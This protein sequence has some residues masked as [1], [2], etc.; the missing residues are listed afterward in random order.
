MR[1]IYKIYEEDHGC[2][3]YHCKKIN[4][5]LNWDNLNLPS[6]NIYIDTFEENNKGLVSVN[7]YVLDEEEGKQS[8]LLYR[9]I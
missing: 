2:D 1:G 8:I 9:K 4:N 7:V 6:S 5:T 3:M